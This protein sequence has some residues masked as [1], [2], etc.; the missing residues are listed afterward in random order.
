MTAVVLTN[1]SLAPS[2]CRWS[3]GLDIHR[4]VDIPLIAAAMI[5]LGHAD[6]LSFTEGAKPVKKKGKGSSMATISA[7]HRVQTDC[8][9]PRPIPP[10]VS[11]P[12]P[13]MSDFC[14]SVLIHVSHPWTKSKHSS[15]L[16]CTRNSSAVSLDIYRI[17]H[18][19]KHIYK[20]YIKCIL[21]SVLFTVVIPIRVV[22]PIQIQRHRH[23]SLISRTE[24][25]SELPNTGRS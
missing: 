15:K 8:R 9:L 13:Q 4:A 14:P 16:L 12:T 25:R 10:P 3:P 24:A 22:I 20:Q 18:S 2:R 1:I 19:F 5:N 21:S 23:H 17:D 6:C 11:S 7:L